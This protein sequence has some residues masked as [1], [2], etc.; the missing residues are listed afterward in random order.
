MLGG[1][2]FGRG[3][4]V[5]HEALVRPQAEGGYVIELRESSWATG[6]VHMPFD[7]TRYESESIYEL[8]V[9]ALEGI[10]EAKDLE[11]SRCGRRLVNAKRDI[12]L[13]KEQMTVSHA[14]GA[15][16][17]VAGDLPVGSFRLVLANENPRRCG[18]RKG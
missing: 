17:G 4:D 11:I 2:F 14:A 12:R 18:D 13:T 10:F 7:F 5:D 8:K 16:N 6:N 1:C 15:V 3:N 9:P